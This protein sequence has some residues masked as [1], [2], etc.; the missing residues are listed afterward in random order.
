VDGKAVILGSQNLTAGGSLFNRD[1]SLLVRDQEVAAYF[2]KIF[3]FDWET[4]AIQE[5]DELVG[6]IRLAQP[7]ENTPIGYKRVPLSELISSD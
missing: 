4:L 2:E 1:A 7:G 6:G 3:V 5:S